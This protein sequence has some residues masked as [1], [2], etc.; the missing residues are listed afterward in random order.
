M[1]FF[2]TKI[3]LISEN[4]LH[5][6]DSSSATGIKEAVI[7]PD[8]CLES[9]HPID[10]HALTTTLSSS[11]TS[12]SISDTISTRLLKEDLPLISNPLQNII[13]L[14]LVTGN[15][16]QSLI[17]SLIKLLLKTYPRPRTSSQL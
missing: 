4:V 10:L 6:T 15:V 5:F 16:P 9:L 17:V 1:N 14:S 13:N 11:I 12:T 2:N 3:I 7:I 8:I